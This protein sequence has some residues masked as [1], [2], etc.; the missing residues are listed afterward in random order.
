M[1]PE[2]AIVI[3]IC[4]FSEHVE[5]VDLVEDVGECHVGLLIRIGVT[6]D[7]V[8]R[9]LGPEFRRVFVRGDHF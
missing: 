5:A 2:L 6:W 8:A 4:E 7:F 9:W 1:F 3:W